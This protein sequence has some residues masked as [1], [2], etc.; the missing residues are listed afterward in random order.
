ML[1]YICY[2]TLIPHNSIFFTG[3]AVFY[4]K[5]YIVQVTT[6]I[7]IIYPTYIFFNIKD[8]YIAFKYIHL[9]SLISQFN[10]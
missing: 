9:Y 6:S 8:W 10:K 7:F 3:I 1:Y 5:I 2:I 4:S